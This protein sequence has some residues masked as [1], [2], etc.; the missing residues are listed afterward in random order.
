MNRIDRII[1]ESIDRFIFREINEGERIRKMKGNVSRGSINSLETQPIKRIMPDGSVKQGAESVVSDPVNKKKI[2]SIMGATQRTYA[3]RKKLTSFY[4]ADPWKP[5]E[6]KKTL[7]KTWNTDEL[8]QSYGLLDK[9][10]RQFGKRNA[11]TLICVLYGDTQKEGTKLGLFTQFKQTYDRLIQ[12]TSE[13]EGYGNDIKPMRSRIKQLPLLF[14][15]LVKNIDNLTK[16]SLEVRK[17]MRNP[18]QLVNTL[19]T[20]GYGKFNP[21]IIRGY[22]TSSGLEGRIVYQKPDN[23]ELAETRKNL[24]DLASFIEDNYTDDPS[25]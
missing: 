23:K 10:T 4:D 16:R 12:Y 14:R 22:V 3:P 20:F 15:E 24:L 21:N 8:Q 1:R 19:Q 11:E 2:D 9:F 5:N 18:Q 6:I 25:M 17:L 13:I 7:R